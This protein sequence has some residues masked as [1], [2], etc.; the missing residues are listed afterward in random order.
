MILI[1]G[2]TGTLG[3]RIVPLLTARGL[4]VRILTRDVSRA[5]HLLGPLVEVVLGDARDLASVQR[6][7]EGV[8]TVISAIQGFQGPGNGSP[9]TV[10]YAGNRNLIAAA[11]GAGSGHFILVS[12]HGAA[13][14]SQ[15]ELSRMKYRAEQELQASGL[16]WNI[17]R[18]TPSMETWAKVIGEP[19]AQAGKTRIFGQ[20]TNAINFISS[21]DVARFIELA[22]VDP[23]MRGTVLDVGGPENLSMRR[24][25]ET[26][27]TET[28]VVGPVARVPLAM[29]RV[30]S[31]VMRLLNPA[32]ARMIQAGVVMDTEDMSFD[33]TDL[34]RR[35]PSVSLTPL[36]EVVHRDYGGPVIAANGAG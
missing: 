1:A 28:G 9:R 6:A 7:M 35:Y 31:V 27:R 22:V 36:T 12:M 32:L 16:A 13:P 25:V 15:M 11:V 18:P 4:S 8:H 29:M 24:F 14:D 17:I 30:M 23:S 20:G 26:F 19:L 5:E 33:P 10:D 2:G 34:M 21:D 3:S